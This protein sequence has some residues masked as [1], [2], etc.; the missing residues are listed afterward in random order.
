MSRER[1]RSLDEIDV[2]AADLLILDFD[3]VVI[4]LAVDW[5]RLRDDI[6]ARAHARW[7]AQIRVDALERGFEEL[8]RLGPEAVADV[9]ALIAS[10][11]R[12]AVPRS[13]FRPDFLRLLG[14]WSGRPFAVCS[15][16]ARAAVLDAIDRV[17]ARE[18]FGTVVGRDDVTRIKPDP[19]GLRLVLER[20]RVAADRALFVGDLSTDVE[21]GREAG[22]PTLLL[23]GAD[24]S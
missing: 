21:A 20:E 14:R 17:D 12:S 7:G 9:H 1:I 2:G 23:D 11:E 22:V 3:G 8:R 24:R 10:A 19:E 16:N 5:D 13:P 6:L 4:D 18:R 15:S